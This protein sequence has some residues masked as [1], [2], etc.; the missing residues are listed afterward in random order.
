MTELGPWALGFRLKHRVGSGLP[1][2]EGLTRLSIRSGKI[3][4]RVHPAAIDDD[5]EMHMASCRVPRGAAQR[6]DLALFHKIPNAGDQLRVV[7]VSG[8]DGAS[9]LNGYAHSRVAGPR[10]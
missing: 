6:N 9:M 5:L 8:S 4:T 1:S 2:I 3:R 10:R 7:A